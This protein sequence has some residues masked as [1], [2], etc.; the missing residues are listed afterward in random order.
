MLPIKT[1]GMIGGYPTSTLNVIVLELLM[2]TK[3]VA[4]KQHKVLF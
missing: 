4:P 1:L 3:W 2:T